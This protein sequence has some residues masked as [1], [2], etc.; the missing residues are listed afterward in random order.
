MLP[1][2]TASY[3]GFVNGDSVAS[4]TALPTL[5]TAATA[6]SH[7]AD[8]PFAITASGAIDPD[9]T[10]SY[11]DGLLTITPVAL[12]ITAD[13]QSKAYG[14]VLPTLT[15][16]YNGFVNGDSA[17]SLT[18]LPILS[19]AA[20]AGSHVADGP[21]AITASGAV[22]SDYNISYVDGLLTITPVALT[23]TADNQTKAYG[24]ALPTL[25]ASYSGFVNGDRAASLTTLP[26]LSTTATA[27]SHV[28]DGP[29]AITPSGAVDT[30]Y[31]I[32]YVSGS[33]TITPVALTI[34]A[35]N[36]AKAYGAALP[37][38]TTSFS[39]FVNGDTAASLTTQPS[40]STSATAASHVSGSPYAITASG[41]V[42]SD[43]TIS[44]VSGTLTVT[45]VALTITAN[46]RTKAYGG[47]LPTLTASY[48]GFVN[49]DSA[50]SL[51]TL[52]TL[53][54]GATASSHVAGNPY[55]IVASGAVD[56]D[57]TISY[58]DGSLTVTPVALTVTANDQTKVYGALVPTLTAGYSGFVN[59]DSAASLTT[60]PTLSTTATV[61]SHVAGNPYVIT[62]SGAADSDYTIS[63]VD[64][65]LT[66]T[67]APLTVRANNQS[68]TYGAS[69]LPS[70]TV[71]YNGLVNGDAPV[72][73]GGAPTVTTS[74]TVHSNVGAYAIVASG[75]TWADYT[76][77]YVNGTLSINPAGTATALSISGSSPNP[78]RDGEAVTFDVAVT[79]NTPNAAT[80][81]GT[82]TFMDG[83]TVLGTSTLSNGSA[84]LSTSR[85]F[86]GTHQ[87]TAVY[88]PTVNFAT[89][90][91]SAATQV[92]IHNWNAV[93]VG[94]A[95]D[96]TVRVL[97]SAIAAGIPDAANVWKVDSSVQ[98]TTSAVFGPFNGWTAVSTAAGADGLTRVLWGNPN[99]SM[100]LWLINASGGIQGV[101]FFGMFAGWTPRQVAVGADNAARVLWTNT[102]GQ[103]V[104]WRVDNSFHVTGSAVFGP[105]SGWSARSLAIDSTGQIRLLWNNTNGSTALWFLDANAN[106]LGAHV[107]APIAGWQAQELAVGSDGTTRI[108]WT[109]TV[110]QMV[111]WNLS[112]TAQ[113]G[114]VVTSGPV[115]GP[116]AGWTALRFAIGPDGKIHVL[117]ANTDG[118]VAIWTLNSDDSYSGAYTLGPV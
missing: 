83:S 76:I 111:V 25:T 23:I 37:T 99:G 118:A 91:S 97:W 36:Q 106:Y 57:Y 109:N 84:S 16:S 66:V 42:D 98:V 38:L 88:T 7:V 12:T 5:S 79:A 62:A 94:V 47:V 58:V 92:V 59:G 51:T 49:G 2:L 22:D 10:I 26:T 54:T 113:A 115:F 9:Y 67:P 4:L 114:F 15:A 13:N 34:T 27:N 60:L 61:G 63:Y 71:T 81:T 93:D 35:D 28:A 17:A 8:G 104:I 101:Q 86:V 73:L 30:D 44:Y 21:F 107:I 77:T 14:D 100:A 1:T 116:V 55:A 96:G 29:F 70:L 64:G 39:G 32:S 48:S 68:M 31:T 18:A 85:L 46:N 52:P 6:S 3:N 87:I 50:A 117:W 72:H 112:W 65:S 95:G 53:N 45:P 43:Y 40:L 110:G 33:L 11:V 74:A 102:S 41:A 90:T 103:A 56:P 75:L 24:D 108:L 78:S 82:I 89:S 19:T 105:F 20:T 69:A 80:P